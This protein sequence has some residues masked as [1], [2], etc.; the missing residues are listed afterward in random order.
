MNSKDLT[1]EKLS[2]IFVLVIFSHA[3]SHRDLRQTGIVN[4]LLFCNHKIKKN[5]TSF[6]SHSR[7]MSAS[8]ASQIYVETCVVRLNTSV[9]FGDY[10]KDYLNIR[11]KS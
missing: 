7:I 4:I 8:G 11:I 6:S 2:I 9:Q 10:N 1:A 3:Q 5:I